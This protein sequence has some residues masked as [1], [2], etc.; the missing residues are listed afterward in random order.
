MSR[1]RMDELIERASAR[2]ILPKQSKQE[3]ITRPWPIVLMTALGAWLVAI[4]FVA[5]LIASLGN[6]LNRG[7][8]SYV[9]GLLLLGGAILALRA[10]KS[11]G[12]VEQLGL[13]ALLVASYLLGIGLYRDAPPT[14]ASGLLVLLFVGVGWLVS[15]HWL[16]VLLGALA[17]GAFIAMVS[18]HTRFDAVQ[19]WGGIHCALLAWA[20]AVIFCDSRPTAA[21][22]AGALIVL[23]GLAAGWIVVVLG[24][25]VCTSGKT[26]IVG[27]GLGGNHLSATTVAHPLVSVLASTVAAAWLARS[28]PALR[29]PRMI[30]AAALLIALSW[31][32]PLLGGTLLVAAVCAASQRWLQAGVAATAAAWVVGSFYYQ[33]DVSLANKGIMLAITGAAFGALACRK[34]PRIRAEAKPKLMPGIAVSLAATLVIANGVIW[35][36]ENLISHGRTVFIELAPVDPRSLMQG[37]YM[38]LNFL[39]PELRG[40]QRRGKFIAK[41][42]ERSVAVMQ[43]DA[44]HT[45]P[46]PDE[47]LIELQLTNAWYFKEGEAKRW[48]KARY[49]EF[50]IDSDGRAL[51]VDLRGPQLE[52]L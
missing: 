13:P 16:R 17:C 19:L 42:D 43:R 20:V 46:A 15:Q 4:P 9:L 33:L 14:V 5:F 23:E 41:I 1:Q 36:K 47:I 52:K 7:A 24:G 39:R 35:Q 31:L 27:A 26:F 6:A 22:N 50:H 45:P 11:S 44:N 37:D 28:W 12:F 34:L 8:L 29:T 40:K 48:E 25:L 2:G 51:L 30:L 21:N 38:R 18:N 3:D 10:A 49:G 32:M